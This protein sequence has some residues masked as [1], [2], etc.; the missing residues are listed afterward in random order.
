MPFF[1]IIFF[2][3][4]HYHMHFFSWYNLFVQGISTYC[5]GYSPVTLV[6]YGCRYNFQRNPRLLADIDHP[7]PKRRKSIAQDQ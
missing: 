1:V 5:K 2:L 7:K 4:L 3:L 6:V